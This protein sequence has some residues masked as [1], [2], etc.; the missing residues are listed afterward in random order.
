MFNQDMKDKKYT[1]CEIDGW[2]I[3]QLRYF[4]PTEKGVCI[5]HI[6][7]GFFIHIL[8]RKKPTCC[9]CSKKIPDGIQTIYTLLNANEI[10]NLGY[11]Q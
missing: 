1:L 4:A 3:K 9:L 10:N 5:Y 7:C 6:K 11:F 8:Y 2:E